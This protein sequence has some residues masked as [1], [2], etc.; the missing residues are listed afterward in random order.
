MATG[1]WTAVSGAAA[2]QQQL[3]ITANN[4]AN[5]NTNGFKKDVPVFKEYLATVERDNDL[6]TLHVG[7]VKEKDLHP[8][9]DKDTAHVVVHGTYTS[10]RPGA[11]QITNN[12]LD[13][14]LEGPGLLE[15]S[16]P[17]GV[18]YTRAGSLVMGQDGRLVT[19]EGYSVLSAGNG[20]TPAGATEADVAGR[21]INLR[22]RGNVSITESGEIYSGADLVG[23]LS[24]VEFPDSKWLQKIGQQFFENKNPQANLASNA[25][26]TI[27]HQGAVEGSNVNPVEEMTNL[28]RA[29]RMFEHDM[30]ALKTFGD[31]MQREAN[32]VGKL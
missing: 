2:Q 29:N 7:P 18:R 27:V 3:D 10:F 23:K 5:V 22:D 32:D 6:P 1:M 15:V 26:K 9:G 19:K 21:F 11:L 25:S 13:V 28:I 8:I 17:S 20:T 16:T 31:L 30:K 14:A 12:P 24:V 4:L